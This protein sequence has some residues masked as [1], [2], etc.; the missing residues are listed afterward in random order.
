MYAS[1]QLYLGKRDFCTGNAHQII[2]AEILRD[3]E[4][5]FG[6]SIAVIFFPSLNQCAG[7]TNTALGTGV[8]FAIAFQRWLNSLSAMPFIGAPWPINKNRHY[9]FLFF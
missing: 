7:V 6:K 2:P 4:W 3:H 5:F 8:S 9:L 1:L